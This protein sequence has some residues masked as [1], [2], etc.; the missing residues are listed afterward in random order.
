[1]KLL[2]L[3]A[4]VLLIA[5]SEAYRFG[6][7]TRAIAANVC[8]A[9]E[10]RF[11]NCEVTSATTF[12]CHC[13]AGVTGT[14]CDTQ[15]AAGNPCASNPCYS[16]GTCTNVGTTSFTCTCPAGLGG[17]TCRSVVVTAGA[18]C[19]CQNSGTCTNTVVGTQTFQSCTC[20]TGF[21]GNLCEYQ[22]SAFVSCFTSP[23][24]NGGTCT[25]L[26]TCACPTGFSG[27]LC[28]NTAAVTTTTA[29]SLTTNP[30]T[31]SLC[32]A[33]ICQNGG[34]CSQ[35]SYNIATCTCV[36]GYTGIYCNV[37]PTNLVTTTVATTT[38]APVPC[39]TGINLCQNNGTCV[40]NPT[41][42]VLQCNC[43]PGFTGPTCA[44]KQP[45]C[46]GSP[47]QNGGT[48]VTTNVPA[49]GDGQCTC[50]IGFSGT[51]CNIGTCSAATNCNNN[52]QC[53]TN[54]G[55][56]TCL[57]FSGTGPNCA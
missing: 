56:V 3:S 2:Y 35:L 4:F 47:C 9:N 1:M 17:P 40:I 27:N 42:N 51:T 21:V 10:C 18:A 19:S 28:Q 7:Q 55:V 22:V 49:T 20:P 45:F 34:V 11:G 14:N 23:C 50:A 29:V 54:N 5:S 53:I 38:A 26:S 32:F 24:Q 13:I 46:T 39:P 25:I 57:C 12:S 16:G 43:V 36:N 41:L 30:G 37:P 52:G 6:K 31:I 33:G 8:N 15:A 44:T 48:C